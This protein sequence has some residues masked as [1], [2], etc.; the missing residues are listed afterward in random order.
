MKLLLL[1][2]AN[3]ID[4]QIVFFQSCWRESRTDKSEHSLVILFI[5][6]R[7]AIFYNPKFLEISTMLT[8]WASGISIPFTD[9]GFFQGFV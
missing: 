7:H 2:E 4:Y 5:C 6:K 1:T 8:A 9:M 3:M